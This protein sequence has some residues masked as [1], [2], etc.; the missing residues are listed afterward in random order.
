MRQANPGS[1]QSS[2]PI[3]LQRR[4][5]SCAAR[6][7]AQSSF[8]QSNAASC[9]GPKPRMRRQPRWRMTTLPSAAG[10][11]LRVALRLRHSVEKRG[12]A[13][14]TGLGGTHQRPTL[15]EEV[16]PDLPRGGAG[17]MAGIGRA[18]T[19]YHLGQRRADVFHRV[20]ARRLVEPLL[21]P[22][23]RWQHRRRVGSNGGASSP[24]AK[25][26]R[27]S[28]SMGRSYSNSSLP[29]R[30]VRPWSAWCRR[31]RGAGCRA[32]TPLWPCQPRSIAATPRS[33]RRRS[34]CPA[35][36]SAAAR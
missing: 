34:R 14:D 18:E 19:V 5:R 11:T 33:A 22:G 26:T 20:V 28:G 6:Q 4:C 8:Q 1:P 12:E 13:G 15:V 27:S 9:S 25:R 10:S 7:P 30:P 31:S 16:H 36:S 3:T 29:A 23:R 2:R 32:M 24:R 21:R 35:R 17:E